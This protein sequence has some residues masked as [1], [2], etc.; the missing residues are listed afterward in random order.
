M[1]HDLGLC[2]SLFDISETSDG[3]IRHG[4]GCMYLKMVF[5]LIVF[6]PFIGEVL[7]GKVALCTEH[8]IRISTHF[9]EDIF[10]PQSQLFEKAYFQPKDQV[11]I[12]PSE[13]SGDLYLDV[14]NVVRFRV[15]QDVF[16][17]NSP[18]SAP[19]ADQNMQAKKLMPPF[20]II[21]SM[22]DT[23]YGQVAWWR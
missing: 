19:S 15:E 6:R 9:F 3:N 2:I 23:G 12:W 20:E 17:D 10:T 22:K 4:D 18:D 8:G 7:V 16:Y 21:A 11:W 14:G 13:D 1:I 5:R